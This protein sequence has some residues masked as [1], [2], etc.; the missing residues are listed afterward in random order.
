MDTARE[1]FGPWETI[2][3]ILGAP[4]SILSAFSY[5]NFVLK[6]SQKYKPKKLHVS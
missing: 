4:D 2:S 6:I 3:C 1:K 5:F